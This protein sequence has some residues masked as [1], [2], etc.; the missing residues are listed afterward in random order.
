LNPKVKYVEKLTDGPVGVGTRY[1]ARWSNRGPSAV[2]VVQ[3]DRPR[4][5]ETTAKARGMSIRFQGTVTDAAPGARY[6]A[7]LELQPKRLARLVA[8]LALLAM[9]RQ[10]QKNMHRIRQALEST[11]VTSDWRR[12]PNVRL[13]RASTIRSGR[14]AGM[15]WQL[16]PLAATGPHWLDDLPDLTCKQS[17][18]PHGL[19]PPRGRIS[20]HSVDLARRR[21]PLHPRAAPEHHG[22]QVRGRRQRVAARMLEGCGKEDTM[23]GLDQ[24]DPTDQPELKASVDNILNRHPAV[25][26]AVGVVRDGALES[27]Y[28][29]GLADIASNTPVTQDTVFRIGSITKT[30]TAIAVLQLSEQGLGDLDAPANQYLRAYKL[31]PAKVHFRPATVRHLLTHTAGISEQVPRSG[32]LRRDYG[33][34]VKLG[35]QIP[36]LAEYYRGGLRLEAEPGTRFRYGDHG[37]A[38]LGQLVEDVSGQPFHRY[39][40]EHVFGP[41]GMTDTTLLRSEV[42]PSRLAAGYRLGSR[43]A[44]AVA[45]RDVVPAGAG[46]VF[47]TPRD[48][49]GYLA[50][51]LGGGSNQRGSVLGPA[52][53]ATMFAPH[54]QPHPRL[55]GLGLAFFRVRAGGHTAV[56]HQ[57][58]MPPYYA[59]IFVASDDGVGVMAFTNGATGAAMW[60]PIELGRLLNALL[61]VPDDVVRTDIPQRPERWGELCGWYALPGPLTLTDV[62]VRGFFGAGIEVL[63]RRGQLVVRVLTPVPVLYR[64]FVLRPADEQ[65]PYLF[66]IDL[67]QYGMGSIL[68]AFSRQSD[69]GPMAVHLEAPMPLSLH[70]QPS[71]TNPRRW[72]EGALGVAAASILGRG[73]VRRRR[74]RT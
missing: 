70:K 68:V 74:R 49:A 12:G 38:T 5:W 65:D 71:T 66:R 10:D 51:L 47:S 40:R 17:T 41:L 42:D 53:L 67:S 2:E 57:G 28:A 35:R 61:G 8:P 72:A 20:D 59:Q 27:F 14:A 24:P 64:G 34:T 29:H 30:I 1:R 58:V 32:L 37:P 4:R 46:A 23:P 44:Q 63:V 15:S 25:G 39:L 26:L 22:C 36:S 69:A 55:P 13:R 60:L 33:E 7:Y 50:A 3:F 18:R 56:E 11:T 48:M 31:V 52:T 62:R 9:R 6:T 21:R 45:Q 54:Y 73:A 19:A 16:A 43:G